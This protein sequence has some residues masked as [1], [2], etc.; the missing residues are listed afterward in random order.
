[1]LLYF[2]RTLTTNPVIIPGVRGT[3]TSTGI[4][5]KDSGFTKC[6]NDET[7]LILAVKVPFRVQSKK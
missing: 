1:M 4:I 2:Y 3:P 6:V 7:P 5:I